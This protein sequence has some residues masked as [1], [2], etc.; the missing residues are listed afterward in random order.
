MLTSKFKIM[1]KI[2]PYLF[3]LP[4]ILVL[5]ITV[6]FPALQA[7]ALSFTQYDYDIT[8]L[9]K[10]SGLENFQ[11]LAKDP[12]YWKTLYNTLLY[13]IVVVPILVIVPLG[14]AILVNKKIRGISLFRVAFYTPVVISMV[15]AGIAWKALY[16]SKGLLNQFLREFGFSEGIA[17]LTSPKIAI[18]SVMAVTIWKGL[19]YYMVIYLAGLQSIPNELY[20]AAAIDGSDSWRKHL[21]ITIPLMRPYIL[22]VGVISTIAATKVFEEIHIMTQGGPSN[23]TKTV[24]YYLYEKAFQDLEINYAC[25]IG[26]ILFVIIFMLSII[27]LKISQ[28]STL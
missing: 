21:D 3:L 18:F 12:V 10:W 27:N 24:V 7:F 8:Q 23:S 4:A 16:L 26:L 15:V 5:G 1:S 22:L 6:L 13:L 9:P 25:T 14:L 11:H 28:N 20:E 17:W 2:T 19:G